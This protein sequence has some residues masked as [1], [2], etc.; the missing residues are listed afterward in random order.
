[1][2]IQFE[3]APACCRRSL[4]RIHDIL[5]DVDCLQELIALAPTIAKPAPKISILGAL[6]RLGTGA[7][8]WRKLR[9][10][11]RGALQPIARNRVMQV[12]DLELIRHNNESDLSKQWSRIREEFQP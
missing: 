6:W 7:W 8:S 5:D 11:T 10:S 9:T 4:G 2:T 12:V 3:H 1:M